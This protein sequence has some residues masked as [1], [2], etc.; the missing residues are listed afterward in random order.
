MV[1]TNT[2]IIVGFLTVLI[3]VG[4]IVYISLPSVQLRVDEDKSTFYV[5]LINENG[6]PYGRWLVSGREYNRLFDGTTLQ[7]RD[8]STITVETFIND[9][10]DEVTIVRTTGYQN[11]A[12]II[13]TYKF[14]GN[15]NDV[16]LF[17]I[18]HTIEIFNAK[19]MFYRYT[20][21]DLKDTGD[22]R[23]LTDETE[24]SF[25]YNMKVELEPDY[26]WAWIGW[27]YGSDSMSAQYDIKSDYEV[28]NI[29]FYDPVS[30]TLSINGDSTKTW[31]IEI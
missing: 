12:Q 19:D 23:K 16:E 9:D 10:T 20:L 28:F 13:D 14:D 29:R 24:L 3:L 26:R 25:G 31:R 30:I 15:I 27:P 22:R 11:G 7:Y 6:E 18:S 17:P 1:E 21:D 8:K 5:K 4:G 2:K